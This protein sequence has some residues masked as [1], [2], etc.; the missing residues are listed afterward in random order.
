MFMNK[1][2][3]SLVAAAM[4]AI[5]M[6]AEANTYSVLFD[7]ANF[8]VTA[9]IT[10]DNSYNV[11]SISGSVVDSSP[12]PISDTIN[13]LAT[14]PAS[15]S[16]GGWNWNN[17][18]TDTAPYID[19]S[20]ILFSA[21]AWT[22]NLYWTSGSTYYLSTYNPDGTRYN[23]GDL[24]SLTVTAVPLPPALVLFGSAVAGL[25]SLRKRRKGAVAA[26]SA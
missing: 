2:A 24:G 18:F 14:T 15:G 8:D 10:A 26:V 6:Q 1:S 9:M 3:I 13:G 16:S 11:T 12:I 22:Y 5:T 4:L 21:G 20:G 17:L 19:N 23:P 25:L 7:G